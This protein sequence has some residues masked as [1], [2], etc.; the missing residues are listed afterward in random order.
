M[1][2]KISLP[3][4]L[5]FVI[6]CSL[7]CAAPFAKSNYGR[8]RERNEKR[9]QEITS[10]IV[11][12][13][14]RQYDEWLLAKQGQDMHSHRN[15]MSEMMYGRRLE[16]SYMVVPS[17]SKAGQ[18]EEAP[19]ASDVFE[20]DEEAI[21]AAVSAR[22]GG[23]LL[24]AI[25]DSPKVDI[26][27]KI[28]LQEMAEKSPAILARFSASYDDM[29][30]DEKEMVKREY[31]L[32]R[33][34]DIVEISFTPVEPVARRTYKGVF[35]RVGPFKI[36]I[37]TQ[38]IGLDSIPK[39]LRARFDRELNRRARIELM[40]RHPI[41]NKYEAERSEAISDLVKTMLEKQFE[42]NLTNGWV[43]I[44]NSWKIPADMVHDVLVYRRQYDAAMRY[45]KQQKAKRELELL[46]RQLERQNRINPMWW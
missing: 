11:E 27:S 34:G 16:N 12:E 35:K 15:D 44:D 21:Q 26:R 20:I 5:V 1:T 33:E 14:K 38:V 46:K 45:Q 30:Q 29:L 13:A 39:K 2:A 4:L 25:G 7:L 37:G 31:P 41:I 22:F 8:L 43:Y 40:E 28:E 3:F 24:D 18:T 6:L 17:S 32:Y 10:F 19:I 42:N 36:M 9:I 23:N